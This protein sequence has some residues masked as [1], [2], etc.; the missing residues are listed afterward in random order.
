M[1]Y[2]VALYLIFY[3]FGLIELK[4]FTKFLGLKMIFN[5]LF[6]CLILIPYWNLVGFL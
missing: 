2:E 6:V 1:P 4:Y 5:G 3:S